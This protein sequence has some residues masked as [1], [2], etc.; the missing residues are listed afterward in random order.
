M[1]EKMKIVIGYDGS[2]CALAALEDLQRAGL[3]E[4]VQAAVVSVAEGSSP[5]LSVP[6]AGAAS[7]ADTG[8]EKTA[9]TKGGV[10]ME[11][12][13]QVALNAVG[14]LHRIFPLWEINAATDWGSPAS[15]ILAQAGILKADLIVVGAHGHSALGR[16]LLGSVSHT[17]VA[18]ASC[19]VRIARGRAADP[20]SPL[21]LLVGI[22]GSEGSEA[23]LQTVASR[24]WPDGTQAR[25]VTAFDPVV[26]PLISS[27]MSPAVKWINEDN[28]VERERA[29]HIAEWAADTLRRASL[30]ASAIVKV[31][32]PKHALL[33]EAED[34]NADA[35]YVG[36][37]G[38]NRLNR[39]L[40]GSV[41][42]SVA[43]RAHCSVEVVRP[44][45]IDR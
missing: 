19:S 34:W 37:R 16:F 25:I 11:A 9:L 13:H 36:A 28:V 27:L 10:I 17:V 31:G 21:R 15:G 35:I 44:G 42:I 43:T 40:L 33:K 7:E 5:P 39:F 32:N 22:D 1:S 3:P 6:R 8:G 24:V 30:D 41:S 23:A 26:P 4:A 14:R 2:D 12:V 29:Q 18:E 38:L 20:A 45:L